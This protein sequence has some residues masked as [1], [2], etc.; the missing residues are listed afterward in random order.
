MRFVHLLQFAA[1]NQQ[2][3]LLFDFEIYEET[4]MQLSLSDSL[5]PSRIQRASS[6]IDEKT[7]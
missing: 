1:I 2:I 3:S 6:R 5:Q 4:E 7:T